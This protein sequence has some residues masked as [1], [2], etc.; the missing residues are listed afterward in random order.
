MDKLKS[1]TIFFQAMLV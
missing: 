1:V